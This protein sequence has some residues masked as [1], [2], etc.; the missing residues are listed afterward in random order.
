MAAAPMKP[1]HGKMN[2]AQRQVIEE[3]SSPSKFRIVLDVPNAPN[4]LN[5]PKKTQ[6]TK[7]ARDESGPEPVSPFKR[8]RTLPA[9][10]K[11]DRT[12]SFIATY[13][14]DPDEWLMDSYIEP[15]PDKR[16][17]TWAP[18]KKDSREVF[19]HVD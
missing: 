6:P 18:H 12:K 19:A 2:L 9:A 14:E 16:P 15:N 5:V 10:P 8:Q 11:I 1:N 7:R 4:V 3:P 13:E 17:I